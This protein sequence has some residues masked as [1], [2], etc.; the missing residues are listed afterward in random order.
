MTSSINLT[1]RIRISR[2]THMHHTYLSGIVTGLLLFV[3]GCAGQSGSG[4]NAGTGKRGAPLFDNLGNHHYKITTRSPDAQRYFDQG[5]TLAYAFNHA[6]AVR[7]FEE[8]A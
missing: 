5:L 1:G 6:E 4:M 8:A 2:G 3:V 7:S